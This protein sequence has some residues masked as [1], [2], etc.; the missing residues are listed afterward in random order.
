MTGDWGAT[1]RLGVVGHPVAHS[2]SPE[3]HE[4]FARQ[5]SLPVDYPRFDVTPGNFVRFIHERAGQR[6]VGLNVTVP[7]K[8]A[9][10]A[11]CEV[12]TDR[13]W[14]AGAVNTLWWEGHVLHGDNTDGIG[15][16][17]D[18]TDNLGLRLEGLAVVVIGAG[19]ACRGILGPLLAAGIGSV[20]VANRT[21]ERAQA[22]A[23]MFKDD[24]P[25]RAGGLDRAPAQP[26]DL[27]INASSSGHQGSFPDLAGGF[28]GPDTVCYDLSYGAAAAPF[29]AWAREHGARQAVDGLGMLV[30]QAAE[31]FHRWTGREPDTAPV[32]AALGGV[33]PTP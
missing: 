29:L 11:L 23:N 8:Q 18:L 30:E 5:F 25:V 31:S 22:L 15:L 33:S 32:L 24:G 12:L 1:L 6:Q 21:V 10:H 19:G 2:R 14:Q 13:A 3:I 26:A 7:H 17:R 16:V 9:A 4:A 28:C 20:H 27:L